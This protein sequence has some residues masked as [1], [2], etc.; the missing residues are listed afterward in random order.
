MRSPGFTIYMSLPFGRLQLLS[1]RARVGLAMFSV[2]V[3]A[4]LFVDVFEHAFQIVEDAVEGFKDGEGSFGNA[5]GLALA[6]G[7]RI[8]ARQRGPGRGRALDA[9]ERPA[10]PPI[11]GVPP[12]R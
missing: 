8:R 9:P 12:M 7:R 3:L 4:F 1:D 2:G 5:V 11:A 6:A 10:Q